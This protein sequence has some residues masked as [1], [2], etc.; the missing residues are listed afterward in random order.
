MTIGDVFLNY[1]YFYG[2]CFNYKTHFIQIVPNSEECFFLK[3]FHPNFYHKE[4]VIMDHQKTNII[5]TKIF[6]KSGLLKQLF[7]YTYIS[8]YQKCICPVQLYES[9]TVLDRLWE[10]ENPLDKFRTIVI[11]YVMK[12]RDQYLKYVSINDPKTPFSI[13]DNVSSIDDLGDKRRKSSQP[14][15]YFLSMIFNINM[16]R[17]SE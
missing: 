17:C 7:K 16:I 4:L 11:N 13:K 2:I 3:N 8:L 14:N 9:S 12:K 5:L 1:L 15:S 10:K 6:K